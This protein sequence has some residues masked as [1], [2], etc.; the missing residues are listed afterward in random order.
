MSFKINLS[1]D[2]LQY[3]R[4]TYDILRL[5]G[6]V[7]GLQGSILTI[8]AVIYGWFSAYNGKVF[9]MTKLFEQSTSKYKDTRHSVTPN[10]ANLLDP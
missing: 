3:S 1:M 7:G 4:Q 9:V 2:K 8:F 5:L 10:M 6:D